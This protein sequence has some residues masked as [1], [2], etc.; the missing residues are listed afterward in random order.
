[1]RNNNKTIVAV[2]AMGLVLPTNHPSPWLKRTIKIMSQLKVSLID[3]K[4]VRSPRRASCVTLM[5]RAHRHQS[6]NKNSSNNNNNN[7]NN[8]E[9]KNNRSGT[10]YTR[11]Q[12]PPS[13][14]KHNRFPTSQS[15][16]ENLQLPTQPNPTQ[17]TPNQPKQ[18]RRAKTPIERH[19][20]RPDP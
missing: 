14:E 16:T 20:T 17:P 1:M 5:I 3:R 18:S 13:R 9:N 8:N 15:P 12:E 6:S 2:Y 7:N 10:R 11:L 4:H 19:S